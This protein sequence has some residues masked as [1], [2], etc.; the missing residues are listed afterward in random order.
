MS[1]FDRNSGLNETLGLRF[2]EVTPERVTLSMDVTPAVLQPY[3]IVHG[4]AWC[5][6]VETAASMAAAAWFGDRGRVVGVSNHTDFIRAIGSGTVEAVAT[7]VHRGRTQ[8]LWLVEI[9]DEQGRLVARGQ[10]RLQNIPAE[11]GVPGLRST[12]LT[13]EAPPT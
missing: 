11:E 8:Q 4:G 12:A 2:G 13:P 7:P 3:G 6:L 5:S 1:G 10:V 9:T